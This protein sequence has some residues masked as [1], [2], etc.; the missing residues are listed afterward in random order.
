M[1]ENVWEIMLVPVHFHP[2]IAYVCREAVYIISLCASDSLFMSATFVVQASW[3]SVG[4]SI[5]VFFLADAINFVHMTMQDGL[6][7]Y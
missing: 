4:Q 6:A 1:K 2:E 5:T 7:A 3:D